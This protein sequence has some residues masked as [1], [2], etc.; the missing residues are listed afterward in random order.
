MKEDSEFES[1]ANREGGYESIVD[2]LQAI[3]LEA[4]LEDC[5]EE[6]NKELAKSLP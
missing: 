1:I 4:L 3:H 5:L 2:I 6:L